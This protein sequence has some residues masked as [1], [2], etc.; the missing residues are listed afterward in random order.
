[1]SGFQLKGLFVVVIF[2]VVVL[3]FIVVVVVLLLVF[4][5]LLLLLPNIF[6]L[7]FGVGFVDIAH[8]VVEIFKTAPY[9]FFG[10]RGRRG[11]EEGRGG[12]GR[13]GVKS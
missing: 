1:M 9:F 3:L 2:I 8:L 11:V 7:S 5:L 4:L 12:E 6:V 10:R 13:G